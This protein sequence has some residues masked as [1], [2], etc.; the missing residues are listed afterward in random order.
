MIFKDNYLKKEGKLTHLTACAS[1][2]HKAGGNRARQLN[3][4]VSR[5]GGNSR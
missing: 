5:T 2:D 4:A 3:T 1:T